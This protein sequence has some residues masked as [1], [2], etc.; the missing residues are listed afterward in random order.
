M[1]KG[2]KMFT[3]F[4]ATEDLLSAVWNQTDEHGSWGRIRVECTALV[5]VI[6]MQILSNG[7]F[8]TGFD[9]SKLVIYPTIVVDTTILL[10]RKLKRI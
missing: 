7:F 3:S 1:V 4:G 6:P 8:D 10:L 2:F 9:F 5:L